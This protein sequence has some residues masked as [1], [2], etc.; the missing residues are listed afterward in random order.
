MKTAINVEVNPKVLVWARESI[1]LSK[2]KASE[3]I[4]I[5]SQLLSKIESGEKSLSLDEI[6]LFSKKYKRSIATLLLDEPPAEKPFP[7][8]RRTVDSKNVNIFHEKTILAVRKA[9]ALA[10]SLLELG[11]ELE[12]KNVKFSIHSS[13]QESPKLVAFKIRER[14]NLAEIRAAQH[15]V[16]KAFE[17]YIEKVESLGVAVFQFSLSAEDGV[18]G[19]SITDDVVPIIGI[20]RGG[21]AA[22]AKIFTLF[23]ELGHLVLNEGGLCDLHGGTEIQIEKWCNA[24]AAAVLMPPDELLKHNKVNEN[25]GRKNQEWSKSDLVAIGESFHVGPLAILRSLLEI[26]LTSSEFYKAAHEKWNKPAFGRAK[27]PEGQNIPKQTIQEK[28]R[29]YVWR[30]FEAYDKNKI[31][32][33]DLSDFLGV[34]LSYIPKTRE[35]LNAL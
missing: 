27:K 28:G 5:S 26:G 20:K 8:D 18:R 4:G 24:F 32:L 13:I 17:F 1:A 23:H 6:K 3:K 25:I 15:D 12:L 22:S 10:S 35:I 34:K 2:N 21:E 19:F 9:R 7:K 31:D 14:L 16:K 11:H 30:A 33:K 29:T